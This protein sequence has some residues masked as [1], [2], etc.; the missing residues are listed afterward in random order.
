MSRSVTKILLAV[1][2]AL[3]ALVI[4][5]LVYLKCFVTPLDKDGMVYQDSPLQTEEGGGSGQDE[6]K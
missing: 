2:C 6:G 5:A 4:G 1:L 3:A